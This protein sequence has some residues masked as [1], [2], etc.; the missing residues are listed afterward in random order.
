MR[1]LRRSP[2]RRRYH[3]VREGARTAG[4]FNEP[5]FV[6]ESVYANIRQSDRVELPGPWTVYRL[7]FKRPVGSSSR[8]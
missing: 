6:D 7:D 4:A 8:S 2:T 1:R 5:E 3:A